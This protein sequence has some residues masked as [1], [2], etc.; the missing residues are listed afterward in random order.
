MSSLPANTWYDAE[1]AR[2]I[3]A[4]WLAANPVPACL[5]PTTPER[6]L[7]GTTWHIPI[8]ISNGNTEKTIVGEIVVDSQSG[9]VVHHS[10][11]EALWDG[12]L[13][14]IPVEALSDQEVLKL[15]DLMTEQHQ[16][17]EYDDLLDLNGEDE[18]D[19]RGRARLQELQNLLK[20]GLL[21]KSRA[22]KVAVQRGLRQPLR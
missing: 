7:N 3:A 18:L 5:G 2:R 13:T 10:P 17:K 14:V 4:D 15:A 16:Q 1:E 9:K 11:I 21:H 22:L 8:E 6:G 12:M 19:E 20:K